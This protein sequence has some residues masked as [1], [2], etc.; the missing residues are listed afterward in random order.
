MPERL[1]R[2]E[3]RQRGTRE[4]PE[5]VAGVIARAMT[6]PRRPTGLGTAGRRAWREMWRQGHWL[7]PLDA[8]LIELICRA[9][10]ELVAL[11]VIVTT[12]GRIVKGSKGQPVAHPALREQASIRRRLISD[13]AAAGFTPAGRRR[14]G[15]ETVT[16]RPIDPLDELLADTDR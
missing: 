14:I 15:I 2:S 6:P 16:P 8:V 13:L 11:E 1:T 12:D 3:R 5:R 10:D 4:H 7:T 9:L